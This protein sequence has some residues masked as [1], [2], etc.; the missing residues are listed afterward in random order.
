MKY[1]TA[2]RM[3]PDDHPLLVERLRKMYI[4]ALSFLETHKL[5]PNTEEEQQAWWAALDHTSTVVHLYSPVERPW[6]IVGFSMVT[7]RGNFCTPM[8]ALARHMRGQGLGQEII[9]HYLAVANGKPLH[10]EQLVSNGAICHLNA[11]LGWK[12]KREQDGVQYLYHPNGT[13]W[14]QSAYDEIV[15]YHEEER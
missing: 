5:H 9:E 8:F 14:P 11:R 2:Y 6:E 15:R 10:G 13:D 4:E 12:V 3:C 7:D 1:L